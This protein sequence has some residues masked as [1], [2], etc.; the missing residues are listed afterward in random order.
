MKKTIYSLV[1]IVCILLVITALRDS[2]IDAVAYNPPLKRSMEGVLKVNDRL[3]KAEI[4]MA[5]KINGP[6][7]VDVDNRG[8][9]YGGTRDGKIIRLLPDGKIEEFVAGLSRP[10]GLHF[11]ARGN[12]IVCDA[13]KGLLSIDP[14]GKVTVLATEAEGVPFRFADDCDV[15]SDGTIYFSDAS[16]TFTVDEYMLDMIESRP[17]GRLLSYDPATKR[18]V[19]LV[20]D[21]YF[22]NGVALSKNEDFVLVNETYRYRIT[23]YWLKGR[24]KGSRD[25]F[26]DNLPGFPDGVSSNRRGSF[27][28][29]LFT[30]RND[31]AD[32][33]HPFP[34]IKSLMARIP[35][36]LWPKPEPYA[37]VL[38]L[39]EEGNIIESLQDPSGSPL[40]EITS[41]QE[42]GGYL[43]LGSLHNDRI[44]RY[45][46]A[47]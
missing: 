12:L 45:R 23:R 8:R 19:V 28:V 37:F 30:V 32:L 10:L 17:H 9:I 5:G 7:D 47:E 4:L 21:L 24:K 42:H 40:Y 38:R 39:D 35:A 26:I 33:I 25:I 43:Y 2:P 18:V 34:W 16:D 36:A 20:K 44:G 22:A 14:A 41:A 13:Y 31:M 15:A 1:G 3:K 11:D 6:E 27:W 46:L 29:A